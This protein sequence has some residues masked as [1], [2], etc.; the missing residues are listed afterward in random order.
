MIIVGAVSAT[1]CLL[2]SG[3][4]KRR[5]AVLPVVVGVALLQNIGLYHQLTT[6]TTRFVPGT[7]VEMSIDWCSFI[8][9]EYTTSNWSPARSAATPA[10][11]RLWGRF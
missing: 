9:F 10:S 3:V 4:C 7:V 6:G 1:V 11:L 2:T 5:Y 8:W